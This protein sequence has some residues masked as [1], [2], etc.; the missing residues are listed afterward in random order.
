MKN[1]CFFSEMKLFQDQGPVNSFIQKETEYNKAKVINYLKSGKIIASCPRKAIDC[2]TGTQISDSFSLHTDG[3]YC[4]GDF[5]V[6]HLEKY[7]IGLPRDFLKK[8][9]A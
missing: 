4:W 7:N 6:Y 3:E 5:L 1:L 2:V 8:I 9:N